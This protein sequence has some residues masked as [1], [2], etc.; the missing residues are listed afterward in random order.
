[1][2]VAGVTE[3]Q[4]PTPVPV[5]HQLSGLSAADAA[6]LGLPPDTPFVIGAS[7]GVLANLGIGVLSPERV[8]V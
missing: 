8:A 6:A 3:R 7:D 4:L 2:D 5:S 1:M